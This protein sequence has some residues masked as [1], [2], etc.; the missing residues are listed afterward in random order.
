MKTL[1]VPNTNPTDRNI[2]VRSWSKNPGET[3]KQGES[4]VICEGREGVYEILA[5]CDGQLLRAIAQAGQ[6]VQPGDALAEIAPD[7]TPIATSA[8]VASP[9][10]KPSGTVVPILM[11]QA[12]QSMEEGTILKWHVASGDRIATGQ[13][14]FEIETDKA[15]LEVE[16]D[17]SG[18][19]SRIVVAEGETVAVKTPVAYLAENDTDVDA[20]LASQ[21][22][23]PSAPGPTKSA[24]V[25][26]T[27]VESPRPIAT[28]HRTDE[29]IKASPA[30]RRLAQEKG[31]ELSSVPP[32]RGPE[33]RI[34][35]QDLEAVVQTSG[36]TS[37][38]VARRPLK[39][40]RKA[41]ARNLTLSKQT[42]PHFYI[43]ATVN[44][45]PMLAY[46]MEQ[47]NR[48]KC[49]VN[50]L[51]IFA[52]S[53]ALREFPVFRT[54]LEG[55]ELAEYPSANIGLAV[56]TEDGLLVP[57]I[58]GTEEMAFE[59]LTSE[60][61]RIVEAARSGRL[62]NAGQGVMTITNLGMFGVEEFGAIIN[63]PEASILAVGAVRD[64][65]RV[66][67]G[68]MQVAKMLTLT[69]SCDHRVIDG[70]AGARF[71]GRL[72][73]LLESPETIE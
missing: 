40:M 16:A 59:T 66:V 71:L 11:P 35:T 56:G 3:L 17:H 22:T 1:R 20:Y 32:G 36:A 49:G 5:P 39:G 26:A 12:G 60:T 13:V 30:A 45:A 58:K 42:V 2:T 51:L 62:E 72:E 41:I 53:R 8:P 24:S 68:A 50:D 70:V 6:T 21:G 14:L 27:P 65:V 73:E 18:R 52:C 19:L 34:L 4:L 15:T 7:G 38:G 46:V 25:A 10:G 69:L 63:P 57:V 48:F 64:G 29:R 67:D 9:S 55:E 33:G 43:R 31:I 44:A 23:S 28:A 61:R 47:R 37:N 54:R